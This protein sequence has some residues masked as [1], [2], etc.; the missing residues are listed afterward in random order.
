LNS[1]LYFG[2]VR[3]DLDGTAAAREAH[4]AS[5]QPT[6]PFAPR[7]LASYLASAADKYARHPDST[8]SQVAVSL[9]EILGNLPHELTDLRTLEQ[10][11]TELDGQASAWLLN[12]LTEAEYVAIETGLAKELRPY[13]G[14]ISDDQL[15]LLR[16]RS[17]DAAVLEK[18]DVP[19][20]SLVY[21]GTA[22]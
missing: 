8:I 6:S 22:A 7:E 19:R 1:Q 4:Q 20:L 17:F 12:Q 5:P 10:K 11:L 21:A 16:R 2:G 3:A 14:K 13:V 15:T 18:N 9:R